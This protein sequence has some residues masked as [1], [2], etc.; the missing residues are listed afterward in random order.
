MSDSPRQEPVPGEQIPPGT[1][2]PPYPPQEFFG[3][4]FPQSVPLP[5][6]EGRTA[7]APFAFVP[8]PFPGV[9]PIPSYPVPPGILMAPP[10]GHYTPPHPFP[11]AEALRQLPRQYC[12]V[13]TH[14]KAATFAWEQHK[15]AWNIIWLQVLI[16]TMLESL[17]V[18]ALLLLE[19]FL[20]RFLLPVSVT[21][22]ISQAQLTVV[23]I[24]LLSCIAYVLISFFAGSGILYL[25]ARA[26]GG[27]GA[28]LPYAYSYALITVPIAILTLLFSL[29]P[30]IGSL[31]QIAGGVYSV[32]LLIYMTMGVH[33]LSG[34]RASAAVLIPIGTGILLV[35]GAYV[36]YIVWIFSLLSTL[37][38]I[39]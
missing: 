6:V 3:P 12:N 32:I 7:D 24:A 15:A 25:V 2:H 39:K 10:G 14:P 5:P 35:I 30:C 4:P 11:L 36:A 31:V 29:L 27:Q 8:P 21:T 9:P 37:P 18:L 28:F 13:L 16:L 38:T 23:I 19:S 26:F 34:G 20:F 17:V 1:A 33:R 22:F